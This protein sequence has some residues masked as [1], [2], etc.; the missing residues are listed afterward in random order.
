MILVMRLD[1]ADGSGRMKAGPSGVRTTPA[2]DDAPHK[3]LFA[4]ESDGLL[5][6]NQPR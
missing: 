1:S 4:R 3:I 5:G 2:T 6:D